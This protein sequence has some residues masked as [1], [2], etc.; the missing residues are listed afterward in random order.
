MLERLFTSKIR[1][2]L[3]SLLLFNPGKNFHLR[4][5]ARL[6]KAN[7]TYVAKEL[8]NLSNIGLVN[9]SK[10][11][12]L[13]VYLLNKD[14]VFVNDLKNLF[15]KTD[16]LGDIIKKHFVNKAK[17]VFIYGSFAKGT[18]GLSSDIDLFVISAIKEDDLLSIIKII[19]DK[20]GRE[21]NYV[22]WDETTFKKRAAGHHLLRTINKEKIIMLVG[23]EDEFRKQI[24]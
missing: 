4:E 10:H 17:F 18:E 14:N 21:V 6:V 1:T 3:L 11:A 2:K 23:D 24:K 9:K 19:E 13:S 5:I 8:N 22:L 7:P 15:L 12:N 20:V 16:Y